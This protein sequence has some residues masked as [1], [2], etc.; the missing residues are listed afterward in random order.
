MTRKR[1]SA[2]ER[3]LAW[4]ANDTKIHH[5]YAEGY[6]V[7]DDIREVLASPPDGPGHASPSRRDS[8][9]ELSDVL[10]CDPMDSHAG[11]VERARRLAALPGESKQAP[12]EGVRQAV[13]EVLTDFLG[14]GAD[15]N[16]RRAM[17]R[18]WSR[19]LLRDK[20]PSP[21]EV[22]APAVV[23]VVAEMERESKNNKYIWDR[24]TLQALR[25]RLDVLP[26]CCPKCRESYKKGR[27]D[28]RVALEV[29]AGLDP[30]SLRALRA[31]P[32][33]PDEVREAVEAIEEQLGENALYNLDALVRT[34]IR[35][36]Q[37]GQFEALTAEGME[38]RRKIHDGLRSQ[39]GEAEP[40]ARANPSDVLQVIDEVMSTLDDV[41]RFLSD[42]RGN[43]PASLFDEEAR[44]L[45]R[46]RERLASLPAS[47]VEKAKQGDQYRQVAEAAA[48]QARREVL[49]RLKLRAN[50]YSGWVKDV[51]KVKHIDDELAKLEEESSP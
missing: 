18:L 24:A 17:E 43:E 3:L 33:L 10:G 22:R 31:A 7:H 4:C 28:E 27:E 36:V 50:T 29:C 47:D 23:R 12:P 20:P 26:V 30:G 16:A 44:K 19:G 46:C 42:C 14:T 40:P 49:A 2:R 9:D 38:N 34:L 39:R 15:D 13:F 35:A 5:P 45:I 37:A 32:P 1:E 48:K 25:K 6:N 8:Y 21:G 51:V 11:R 41:S